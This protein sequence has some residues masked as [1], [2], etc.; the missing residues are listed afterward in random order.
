[1]GNIWQNAIR[2]PEDVGAGFWRRRL[3]FNQQGFAAGV[4][5]CKLEKGTVITNAKAYVATAFNAGTTNVVTLGTLG[6]PSAL[7]STGDVAATATGYKQGTGSLIGQEL[8][9]DTQIY[10]FF[11]QTGT[12]ATAG[13]VDFHIHFGNPRNWSDQNG[14][15]AS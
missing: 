13:D 2:H 11:S 14:G 10:A 4:P 3:L 6:S 9:A 12:A 15:Q 5:V 7:M 1:M 8:T